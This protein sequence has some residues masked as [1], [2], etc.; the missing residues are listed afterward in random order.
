MPLLESLWMGVPCVCS[1]LPV[2]REN[3]GQRRLP[4]RSRSMTA[5]HGGDALR[6][7]LTDDTLHARLTREATDAPVAEPG[8]AAA[9]DRCAAAFSA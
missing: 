6:R 5:R 3:S 1:D 4:A 7:I 2:L 8:A 9:E